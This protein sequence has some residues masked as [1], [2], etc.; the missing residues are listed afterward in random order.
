MSLNYQGIKVNHGESKCDFCGVFMSQKEYFFI[1]L[2][3]VG[4]K[5]L[6]ICEDCESKMASY[7]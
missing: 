7:G 3:L 6:R 4:G 5:V 1:T 2:V